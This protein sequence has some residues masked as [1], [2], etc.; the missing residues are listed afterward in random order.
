MTPSPAIDLLAKLVAFDTTSSKSNLELIGF[1]RDYLSGHGIDSRLIPSPEGDKANLWATI[2]PDIAGGTI[3]SGHT[4]TVPVDGQDWSTDPF[5]LT[6]RGDQLHGRGACDMKGFVACVLAAVP[7]MVRADLAR[8]IH[9]AFSYD[10]EI[11][12]IGVIGLIDWLALQPISPAFC[13]VGEPTMME[14][15]L[16]HK[17]KRS[18]R[19]TVTGRSCHSALAP[20][21]VNAVEYGALM[22]AK[23]HAMAARMETSGARDPAYDIPHSTAHTVIF[24]GGTS[25]NIVPDKAVIDCEF[26]VLPGEDSD[27]LVQELRAYADKLQNAMRQRHPESGIEIATDAAF[28]G[29]DTPPDAE[30]AQAGLR[31][32][33]SNRTIKVAYGTEGGR[34]AAAPLSLPTIICGPGSITQAHQPDEFIAIRQLQRCDQFLDRLI[35]WSSRSDGA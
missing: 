12:C 26:R 2:G 1:I 5:T 32:A 29:L 9:L 10:E 17:A 27:A 7:R 21:G 19:I 15:G 14:V 22:V 30:I 34:F 11:G 8:P 3:L 20:Q 18:M 25:L 24:Q 33:D 13:V 31:F 16:G 28:P 6:Q 23:I 35:A 4:D